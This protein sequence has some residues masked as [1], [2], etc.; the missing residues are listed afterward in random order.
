M[1]IKLLFAFLAGF[2]IFLGGDHINNIDDNKPWN[3]ISCYTGMLA[4][5]VID[6]IMR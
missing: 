2:I 3:S 1:I 4:V 6:L 5:F